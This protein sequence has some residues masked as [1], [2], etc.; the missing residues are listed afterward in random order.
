MAA[1]PL[2][3][4]IVDDYVDTVESLALILESD[5]HQVRAAHNGTEALALVAD[6]QP[7]VAILD[8]LMPEI[9]GIALADRLCAA[10]TCRPLLVAVS[11]SVRRDLWARADKFDHHFFK[12]IDPCVLTDVLKRYAVAR[13]A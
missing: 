8:L 9:D 4:L 7:N 12:P 2:A 5:G 10:M 6:W 11:G 1:S 3:V 13:Q